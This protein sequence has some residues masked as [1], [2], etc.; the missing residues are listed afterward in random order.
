MTKCKGFQALSVNGLR[1]YTK[2]RKSLI[3]KSQSPNMQVIMKSE[4]QILD[5]KVLSVKTSGLDFR[6][7]QEGPDLTVSSQEQAATEWVEASHLRGNLS[8]VKPLPF[9]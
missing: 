5:E 4:E 3:Q 1:A 6:R 7:L 9:H 2:L 8:G